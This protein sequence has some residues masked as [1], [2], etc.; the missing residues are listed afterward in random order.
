MRLQAN[1]FFP[2]PPLALPSATARAQSAP[3]SQ[4]CRFLSQFDL[5]LYLPSTLHTCTLARMQACAHILAGMYTA[6]I[7]CTCKSHLPLQCI[8]SYLHLCK[9]TRV[10]SGSCTTDHH[11]TTHT[12]YLATV[13]SA[14]LSSHLSPGLSFCTFYSSALLPTNT[15]TVEACFTTCTPQ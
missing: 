1:T 12:L 4:L 8:L 10:N 14:S 3:I 5:I 11:M 9:L 7:S 15:V 2:S 13:D 6:L